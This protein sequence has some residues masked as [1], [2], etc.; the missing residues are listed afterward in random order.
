MQ[1]LLAIQNTGNLPVD[2]ALKPWVRQS[3]M[4]ALSLGVPDLEEVDCDAVLDHLIS[5]TRSLHA[6][7]YGQ[8]L[9]SVAGANVKELLEMQ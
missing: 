9:E 3:I 7:R 5:K 8:F 2:W 4:E 6:S 1:G